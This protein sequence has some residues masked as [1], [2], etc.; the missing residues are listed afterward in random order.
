MGNGGRTDSNV[1]G[2]MVGMNLTYKLTT[3]TLGA[4][5]FVLAVSL[6]FANQK[7]LEIVVVDSKGNAAWTSSVTTGV[8][9]NMVLNS[10]KEFME[11]INNFDASSAPRAR[12]RASWFLSPRLRNRFKDEVADSVVVINIVESNAYSYIKWNMEPNLVQWTY[13][14][15]RVYGSFD[16]VI[17]L[18]GGKVTTKE[19][20]MTVDILFSTSTVNR[21]SGLYVTEFKYINDESELSSILNKVGK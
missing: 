13:P 4:V 1:F 11:D 16:V 18:P 12:E 5:A 17:E 2:N 20:N 9:K 21:P 15:A 14:T 7:K 3:L 10:T 8:Y 6:Y 19:H